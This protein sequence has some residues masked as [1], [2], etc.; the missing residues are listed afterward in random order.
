MGKEIVVMDWDDFIKFD[1]NA[2]KLKR[3]KKVRA[4]MVR[5]GNAMTW[6]SIGRTTIVKTHI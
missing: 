4:D 1:F 2:L 5:I 6:G 3:L